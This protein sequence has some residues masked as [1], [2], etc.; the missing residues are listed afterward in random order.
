M[1]PVLRMWFL[2]KEA[3]LGMEKPGD[4]AQTEV[5]SMGKKMKLGCCQVGREDLS[6]G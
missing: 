3:K 4:W 2:F 6:Q 1:E 5:L